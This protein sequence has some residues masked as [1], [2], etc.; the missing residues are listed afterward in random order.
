LYRREFGLC[1]HGDVDYFSE[2]NS[3]TLD[4][5]REHGPAALDP[6]G[7]EGIAQIRLCELE[8]ETP[9][10]LHEVNI[11]AADDLF[12]CDPPRPGE[13]PIPRE[14]RLVRAAFRLKLCGCRRPRLVHVCP[15]NTLKLSRHCHPHAVHR[16]LSRRGFLAG[17][18]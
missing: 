8:V 16:W 18:A 6:E 5:L 9:G 13:G 2:S 11:R 15:P 4:P 7:V 1:L 12:Q 10:Q 14:G 3:Y 17:N